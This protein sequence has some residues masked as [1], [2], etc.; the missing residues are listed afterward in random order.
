MPDSPAVGTVHKGNRP[1]TTIDQWRVS[2]FDG[3]KRRHWKDGRS[4]KENA[5]T[6]LDAAPGLQPDIAQLLAACR[7][8]GPLRRWCAEPEA[9]ITID[10]FRGPPNIDLL[11]IAEDDHG[12]VV[13]AIEAKADETFGDELADQY[14]SARDELVRQPCSKAVARIEALLDRFALNIEHPHVRQLRYQLLT[15]TAAVLTEANRRNRRSSARAVLIV[16]E[17]VTPLTCP[18]K[19]E[20]NAADPDRFLATALDREGHLAPGQIAGPFLVQGAPTL[21]VGKARTVVKR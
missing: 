19:R 17:F 1:L 15:V 2:C 4:A 20:R 18:E 5:R 14:Q 10:S 3:A 7:D 21:Y 16:H 12:P 9:V 13:I 11:V 8:I 6:W